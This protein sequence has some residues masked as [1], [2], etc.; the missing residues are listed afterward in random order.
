MKS[1]RCTQIPLLLCALAARS[2]SPYL[3]S[4]AATKDSPLSAD[5]PSYNPK[6]HWNGPVWVQWNY[7]IVRGLLQYGHVA[8]ARALTAK[9]SSAM[10]A[11]LEKDHNFWEFCSPDEAWSG[12]EAFRFRDH[13]Q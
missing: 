6:G 4:L 7:L 1:F 11:Q 5:D 2:E 13:L 12:F 10:I 8:E 9:I 3:S